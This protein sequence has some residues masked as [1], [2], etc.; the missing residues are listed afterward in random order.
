MPELTAELGAL[1]RGERL[2]RRVK[3]RQCE[4]QG[5]KSK[6]LHHGILATRNRLYRDAGPGG[7][8]RFLLR[9]AL[10]RGESLEAFVRYRFSAFDRDP[11]GSGG[12]ARLRSLDGGEVSA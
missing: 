10:S 8:A 12:E 11:V 5:R 1:R 2:D 3:R 6:D 7:S 4:Q 9:R